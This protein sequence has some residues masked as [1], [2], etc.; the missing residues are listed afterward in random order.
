M[1]DIVDML[2]A[3]PPEVHDVDRSANPILGV[4]ATA[5]ECYRYLTAVCH[6]GSRTLETGSGLS[7]V[8]FAALRTQHTCITPSPAEE[9]R[10]RAYCSSRAIDLSR[11][12]FV[13]QPSS[14]ALPRLDRAPLDLVL[15]DGAHGFP[16]PIV[17][18]F[19][20]GALLRQSGVLVLDDV[21]LPAVALVRDFLDADQRWVRQQW[22]PTWGAW[23]RIAS[24][25]LSEDWWEQPFYALPLRVVDVPR[26]TVRLAR[27]AARRLLG[28]GRA[29]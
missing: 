7:T 16:V 4:W 14:V 23:A 1:P 13:I 8:L 18:W 5:P 26:T 27:G 21:G 12:N 9:D 2:L 15:I 19:Y 29:G 17:D 6:E 22:A 24:G 28:R 20:A 25:E 11:V 3:D 10:I